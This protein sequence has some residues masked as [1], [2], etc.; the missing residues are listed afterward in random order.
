T[1][2]INAKVQGPVGVPLEM[3]GREPFNVLQGTNINPAGGGGKCAGQLVVAFPLGQPLTPADVKVQGKVRVSDGRA[4]HA[5][6]NYD[7]TGANINV[8][9]TNAAVESTVEML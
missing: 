9:R 4:K 7:V 2:V 5:L 1:G 6:W 8:Q 3:F